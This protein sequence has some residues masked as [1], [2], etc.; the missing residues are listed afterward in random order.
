MASSSPDE[1]HVLLVDDDRVTRTVVAGLL[2]KCRYQGTSVPR[3][4]RPVEH[5]SARVAPRLFSSRTRPV[6]C[7]RDVFLTRSPR[8][9]PRLPTTVTSAS[10]GREALAL[11][12][13]GT[14][15]NLLLTDVMMPDV[16]GPALLHRV[17]EDPILHEMPVVMMSSNEHADVVLNCLRLGAEDYLLKPVT[18]KAVKHMWAHVWRRKQ[19][20]QM[21]PR[22]ENGAEV[23]EEDEFD[24]RMASGDLAATGMDVDGVVTVPDPD[25]FSSDGGSDSDERLRDIRD[26][27]E[28]EAE[29][30]AT[31]LRH[32]REFVAN[33]R[34]A[35]AS[36]ANEPMEMVREGFA[37]GPRSAHGGAP[38]FP[39]ERTTNARRQSPVGTESDESEEK[40]H[41]DD[42]ARG[43]PPLDPAEAAMLADPLLV[44]DPANPSALRRLAPLAPIEGLAEGKTTIRAWLDD[45]KKAGRV[46]DRADALHVLGGAARLLARAHERGTLLGAM[47]ASALTVTPQGDV[48][49]APPRPVT[50]PRGGVAGRE[51][52]SRDAGVSGRRSARAVRNRSAKDEDEEMDA[53]DEQDEQEMRVDAA[54]SSAFFASAAASTSNV[55]ATSL[56]SRRLERTRDERHSNESLYVS[57]EERAS[58]GAA[59]GAGAPAECFAL[60]VL[61][62]ETCWPEVAAGARGDVGALLAATLR[63]DGAGAAALAADPEESALAKQLLQPVPGNRPSAAQSAALLARIAEDEARRRDADRAAEDLETETGWRTSRERGMAA[64]KRRAELVALAGFLRANREARAREAQAHRVRSALLAHALRQLGGVGSAGSHGGFETHNPQTANNDAAR[65]AALRASRLERLSSGGSFD[66]SRTTRR[67]VS[68]DLVRPSATGPPGAAAAFAPGDAPPGEKPSKR[69]RAPDGV[70]GAET[71]ENGSPER[72]LEKEKT[73]HAAEEK[74]TDYLPVRAAAT[75]GRA[76][77]PSSLS[78]PPR[79]AAGSGLR[80][81]SFEVRRSADGGSRRV[82]RPPSRQ[83]SFNENSGQG[84]VSRPSLDRVR[85][86]QASEAGASRSGGLGGLS[87]R[88]FSAGDLT[89]LDAG[90]AALAAAA[91]GHRPA[92]ELDNAAFEAL[93]D[94]FFESCARAVAPVARAYAQA[95]HTSHTPARGALGAP[96]AGSN[97][98]ACSAAAGSAGPAGSSLELSSA[99]R[100]SAAESAANAA[101]AALSE[102]FASFGGELAQ[103]VRKTRLRV[104]SD[105]SHGDVHSFGEMICSVG[106]DRDGEFVATAGI[107]KRLR[108]YETRAMTDMGAAVQCPVA[109]MRVSSKL[110]SLA[111]NPYVKKVLASADYDGAIRVWDADAGAAAGDLREHEKR[112]WSLDFS[113]LDPTRLASGSDDGTVRVWST[114]QRASTATIRCRAN[115]CSVQFSPVNANVVAF[116]SAEHKTH[117]YDLRRTARPLVVLSGHK[118]AVSYVRWLGAHQLVTASTDNTLKLWDVTKG[119]ESRSSACDPC[120]RTFRGHVNRRNFIGLDVSRGGRIACGSEDNTVRLFSKSVPSPIA[121]Q[122]LAVTAAFSDGYGTVGGA[123]GLGPESVA[124]TKPGLFVSAVA[125]SPAGDRILAANSCGAVKVLQLT[126]DDF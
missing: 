80:R 74:T 17:R 98:G 18:K 122:S 1:V 11:L 121:T 78:P 10:S 35:R 5:P 120:V 109:E 118:R 96:A 14:E 12:E 3:C 125:W 115:V 97:G 62:V 63:P 79:A 23:V 113:T 100:R 57:P 111:W 67:G 19:R 71:L 105:V 29:A 95:T 6:T 124:D 72:A 107:S 43:E 7:P 44:R 99:A 48:A 93:E 123:D 68:F 75:E 47:R 106:W 40:K 91:A 58:G 49:L 27:G 34:S 84:L 73:T 4:P 81:G 20:N 52:D 22:F 37:E 92:S 28:T 88:S 13:R 69:R 112:V 70:G 77:S 104:V 36:A 94:T 55:E 2:R 26:D 89:L 65:V 24:Q 46:P 119:F 30:R 102:A 51:R 41:R 60:G 38:L 21:V 50:P 110:S 86:L 56:R 15:F 64:E 33:F 82:S 117:V 53:E 9:P 59:A 31:G 101:S 42:A 61:M 126:H 25:E 103:C 45:A 8:D 90:D 76:A 85:Q 116:S 66:K 32:E 87:A 16:D 39:V 108:V 114:T 83:T 54:A